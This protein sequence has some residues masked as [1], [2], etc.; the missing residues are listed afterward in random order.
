MLCC[1]CYRYQ[2]EHH[3]GGDRV[4]ES[5]MQMRTNKITVMGLKCRWSMKIKGRYNTI[6]L[7]CCCLQG[8]ILL[9]IHK[10][11]HQC[12]CLAHLMRILLFLLLQEEW[13]IVIVFFLYI[14]RKAGRLLRQ[15]EHVLAIFEAATR[16]ML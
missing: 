9:Y 16:T 10:V 13:W 14:I 4:R 2:M 11:W 12:N 3:K 8:P 1:I 7:A 5:M 6:D 15:T